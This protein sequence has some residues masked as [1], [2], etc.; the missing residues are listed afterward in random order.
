MLQHGRACVTQLDSKIN[1]SRQR[2]GALIFTPLFQHHQISGQ[3]LIGLGTNTDHSNMTLW[4]QTGG[5]HDLADLPAD[6]C[7]EECFSLQMPSAQPQATAK[8][9]KV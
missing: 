2:R 9:S 3:R 6:L 5:N 8:Y 7:E 1:F 4:V